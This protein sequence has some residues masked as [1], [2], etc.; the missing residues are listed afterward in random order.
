MDEGDVA[1]EIAA[2]PANLP[3]LAE[4]LDWA[5]LEPLGV[6]RPDPQA[7]ADPSTR[8]HW[9]TS[10]ILFAPD[11]RAARQDIAAV[12]AEARASG[13][14]G[15]LGVM[16]DQIGVDDERETEIGVVFDIL[17]IFG[18]GRSVAARELADARH[19]A[20][21]ARLEAAVWAAVR[22][23]DRE[24]AEFVLRRAEVRMFEQ[25]LFESKDDL[26]TIDLLTARGRV[27]PKTAARVAEVV[28]DAEI[29][30]TELRTEYA[31][32]RAALAETSGILYDDPAFER[33]PTLDLLS[34]SPDFSIDLLP[35]SGDLAV[36]ADLAR[37]ARSHPDLRRLALEYA[38]AEAEVRAAAAEAWP[39]IRLGPKPVIDPARVV[40][41]GLL[42]IEWPIF[43]NF[44]AEVEAAVAMRTSARQM[45]EDRLLQIDAR[46]RAAASAFIEASRAAALAR[47]NERSTDDV[48]RAARASMRVDPATVDEW[49]MAFEQRAAALRSLGRAEADVVMQGSAYLEFSGPPAAASRPTEILPV[50]ARR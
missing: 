28:R 46:R 12:A 17:G 36:D 24:F 21:V 23:S 22:R 25:L 47:R 20:A 2:R 29:M 44:D 32:S 35:R 5:A 49:S 45:F 41:G 19:R 40:P 48:R 13:R 1:A 31:E 18:V 4:A 42:E 33:V 11:V 3:N 16:V 14:P 15:P 10:A 8:D 38:V 34:T 37:L 39:E 43:R 27:A 26:K 30:L 50:E 6:T 7:I 9:R